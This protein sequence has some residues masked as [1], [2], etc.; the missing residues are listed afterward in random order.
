MQLLQTGA[1]EKRCGRIAAMVILTLYMDG[2][3]TADLKMYLIATGWR[4]Y[5]ASFYVILKRLLLSIK[6]LL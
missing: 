3:F 4:N 5:H 2:R 6:A 1:D